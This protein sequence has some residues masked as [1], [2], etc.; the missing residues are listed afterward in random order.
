MWIFGEI[1]QTRLLQAQIMYVPGDLERQ[2]YSSREYRDIPRGL[3]NS[4]LN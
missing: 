2:P 1:F 3:G 4:G